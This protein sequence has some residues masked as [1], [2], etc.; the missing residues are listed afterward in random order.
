MMRSIGGSEEHAAIIAAIGRQARRR[1]RFSIVGLLIRAATRAD[2][3]EH[4]IVGA[5]PGSPR[6]T[7]KE[8]S[9]ASNEA[10]GRRICRG[11]VVRPRRLAFRANGLPAA[12]AEG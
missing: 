8:N 1:K 10:L 12:A 4:T 11:G 5:P 7:K 2:P 9:N 6:T 3:D